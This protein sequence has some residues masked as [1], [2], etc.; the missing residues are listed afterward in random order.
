MKSEQKYLVSDSGS[1]IEYFNIGE[2]IISLDN[3]TGMWQ[4]RRE[5]ASSW[6]FSSCSFSP[7][8]PPFSFLL[9]FSLPSLSF[10]HIQFTPIL[11]FSS[12]STFFSSLSLSCSAL[13]PLIL[14]FYHSLLCIYP[15]FLF[16]PSTIFT[17][18]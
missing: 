11:F 10:L 7:P 12:S 3:N 8:V 16:L 17:S 14:I 4:H 15:S 1:F 2:V 5:V 18:S 9:F 13:S 6:R